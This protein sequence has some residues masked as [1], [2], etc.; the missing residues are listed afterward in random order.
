FGGP[1]GGLLQPLDHLPCRGALPGAAGRVP[2][3]LAAVARLGGAGAVVVLAVAH[4]ADGADG[5]RDGPPAVGARPHGDGVA[6]PG[7][8]RLAG[9]SVPRAFG[10]RAAPGSRGR[11]L[12]AAI[13]ALFAVRHGMNHTT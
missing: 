7:D 11:P 3:A 8:G 1:V 9:P 4:G 6:Q 10:D 5:L 12:G 2:A 13:V